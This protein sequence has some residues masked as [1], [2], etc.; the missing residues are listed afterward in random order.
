MWL[1]PKKGFPEAAASPLAYA[2]PTRRDE[3]RPGP[4]VAAKAVMSLR[5]TPASSSACCTRGRIRWA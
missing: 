2:R 3:A 4:R 1:I 5:V